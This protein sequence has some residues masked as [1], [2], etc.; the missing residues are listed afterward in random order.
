M[1]VKTKTK[2]AEEDGVRLKK[3]SNF[4]EVWHR[5]RKNKLSMACLIFL[6]AGIS[7]VSLHPMPGPYLASNMSFMALISSEGGG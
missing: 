6:T 5:L 2:P 1:A 3:R 4:G 7:L